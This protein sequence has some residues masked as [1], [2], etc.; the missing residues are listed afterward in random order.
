MFS[1]LNCPNE[2]SHITQLPGLLLVG[3]DVVHLYFYQEFLYGVSNSA[4]D[5]AVSIARPI[6]QFY[7]TL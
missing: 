2:E 4:H 5:S 6:V 7:A 1:N 3:V